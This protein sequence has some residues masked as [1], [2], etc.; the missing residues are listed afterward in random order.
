MPPA[1]TCCS[2]SSAISPTMSIRSRHK[3]VRPAFIPRTRA[4]T[5]PVPS[6][7]DGSPT[8]KGV[9]TGAV[10]AKVI[11]L[12]VEDG[13]TRSLP[14]RKSVRAWAVRARPAVNRRDSPSSCQRVQ[15]VRL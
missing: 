7:A 15:L 12:G 9:G 8:T 10:W 2:V 14:K 4:A 6:S 11:G 1:A 13:S 5:R 3:A